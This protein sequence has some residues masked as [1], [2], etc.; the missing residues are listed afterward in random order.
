MEKQN[1]QE[2]KEEEI[3]RN[4]L[5][6]FPLSI[7]LLESSKKIYDCNSVAELYLDQSKKELINKNFFDIFSASSTHNQESLDEMIY[8]IINFDLNEI[9]KFEFINYKGNRAWVEGFFSSVKFVNK[10]LIQ[11]ILQ[12]T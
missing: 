9:A 10:K 7:F 5:D 11:I 2:I 1:D 12:G 6:N 8:N 4:L 3:F